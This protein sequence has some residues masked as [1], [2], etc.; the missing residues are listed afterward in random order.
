MNIQL[1]N[2]D[3]KELI[4]KNYIQMSIQYKYLKELISQKDIGKERQNKDLKDLKDL[5]IQKDLEFQEQ[6]KNLKELRYFMQKNTPHELCN[7]ASSL[8]ITYFWHNFIKHGMLGIL[9]ILDILI[10]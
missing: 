10:M 9:C 1:Q 5:V 8:Q 6:N 2:E 4:I 3:L 7:R